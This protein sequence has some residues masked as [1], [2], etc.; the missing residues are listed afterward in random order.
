MLGGL[1]LSAERVSHLSRDGVLDVVQFLSR[2]AN[3][4]IAHVLLFFH[5]FLRN[6]CYFSNVSSTFKINIIVVLINRGA[7]Q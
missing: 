3:Y 6:Y 7:L 2:V 1:L 5:L 4:H